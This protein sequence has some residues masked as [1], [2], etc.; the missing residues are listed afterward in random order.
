MRFFEGVEPD[1]S[2]FFFAR[3]WLG[4]GLALVPWSRGPLVTRF[5][6]PDFPLVR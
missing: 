5:S 6:G 2:A 4:P 1:G 3:V